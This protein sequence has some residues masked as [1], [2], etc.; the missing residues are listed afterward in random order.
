MSTTVSQHSAATPRVR[1][2]TASLWRF[3]ALLA[4]VGFLVALPLVTVFYASVL[5]AI[6]F[7]GLDAH[8]TLAN[9]AE[10]WSPDLRAALGNTA[11]IGVGGTAIAVVV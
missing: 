1:R 2:D 8:W 9:Y 10:V 4:V 7:T 11:I 6:P 5:T 3:A